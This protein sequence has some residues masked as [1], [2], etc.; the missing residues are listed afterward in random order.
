MSPTSTSSQ[1]HA[2]LK[3]RD[4]SAGRME[5]ATEVH[6]D[7]TGDLLLVCVNIQT[8]GAA[9]RGIVRGSAHGVRAMTF[10]LRKT[11]Y[12]KISLLFL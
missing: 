11:D 7:T 6:D 4:T 9:A 10:R 3:T 12:A 2:G 8:A 5:C 1:L